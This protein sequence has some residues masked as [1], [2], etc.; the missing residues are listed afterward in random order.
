VVIAVFVRTLDTIDADVIEPG[1]RI[2]DQYGQERVAADVL[3]VGT[4]IRVDWRDGRR[5]LDTPDGTVTLAPFSFFH[6]DEM[7]VLVNLDECAHP[8]CALEEVR[9]GRGFSGTV[10]S[11][12]SRELNSVELARSLEDARD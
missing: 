5:E 1:D 3:G 7:V 12:C 4:L 6:A 8:E 9:Y 11:L 2:L 10:C